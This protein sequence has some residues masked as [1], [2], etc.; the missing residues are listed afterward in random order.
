LQQRFDES[1]YLAGQLINIQASP[2]DGE[3]I[4]NDSVQRSNNKAAS[5]FASITL[6]T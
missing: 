6:K 3:L 5:S 1:L 2:G 4:K